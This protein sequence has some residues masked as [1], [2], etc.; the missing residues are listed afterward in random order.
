[1]TTVLVC[2]G[3]QHYCYQLCEV[4]VDQYSGLLLIVYSSCSSEKEILGLLLQLK[5]CS[6][7]CAKVLQ[8]D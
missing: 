7:S 1:M 5:H 8:H 6:V 3:R 4:Q 2:G